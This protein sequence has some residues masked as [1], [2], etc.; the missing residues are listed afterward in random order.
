M[1]V[2]PE[3]I[4]LCQGSMRVSNYAFCINSTLFPL[5]RVYHRVIVLTKKHWSYRH[6]VASWKKSSSV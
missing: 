6:Y 5:I 3:L 4:A 1:V 2:N